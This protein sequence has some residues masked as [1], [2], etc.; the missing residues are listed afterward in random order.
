[1]NAIFGIL[2][3]VF[4]FATL[5]TLIVGLGALSRNKGVSSSRQSNQLMRLRV[6]CQGGAI[7]FG[8]LYLLTS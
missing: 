8:V 2:A 5:V 6:L 1:M 3:V 7:L 4:L